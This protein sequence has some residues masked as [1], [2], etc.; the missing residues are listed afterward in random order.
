MQKIKFLFLSLRPKHW[1]KNLFIFVA[2]FFS[3]NLFNADALLKTIAGF[4]C[5]CGV[6]SA[7]YL[8]NDIVDRKHDIYH[9]H[10]Q[11][12]P[13]ASG[14]LK[15]WE[16]YALFI[17]LSFVSIIFSIRLSPVFA[18]VIIA[19]FIINLFYSLYLKH[20]FLLDVMCI[21][22]G[23]VLRVASGAV[24]IDVVLS[25]WVVMCTLLLSLLLGFGKRQEELTSLEGE[26]VYHRRVL[27]EYDREF[28]KLIPYTLLSATLLCYM[29]YTVSQETVARFG[30]KNLI[31]TTPFVIYGLMRYVYIA[32]E[33][34]KGADPTQVL[35][36]DFPTVLN[37]IFWVVT[38]GLIIYIK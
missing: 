23:F 17:V 22:A 3:L 38:F 33:K 9:P 7:H 13:I 2:P 26:S 34:D 12:R 30:T 20:V 21:A 6:A 31:Y 24:L 27:K 25:E 18:I 32:Y 14:R 28:L 37:I 1:V 29:L 11:K 19:Y 10:K 8:F 4:L 15:L 5:W 16:A 36:R 35:F